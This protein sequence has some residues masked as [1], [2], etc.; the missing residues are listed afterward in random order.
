MT[1]GGLERRG[2]LELHSVVCV[3]D[4]SNGRPGVRVDRVVAQVDAARPVE[5]SCG[6]VPAQV[7]RIG[8]WVK[9]GTDAHFANLRITPL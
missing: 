6:L 7:G 8:L 4:D 2:S 1:P 3:P 5:F 9:I